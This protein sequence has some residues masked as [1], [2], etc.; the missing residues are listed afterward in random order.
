MA[1]EAGITL[2]GFLN[3]NRFNLYTGFSRI[4]SQQPVPQIELQY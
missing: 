4:K 2:A 3:N 1:N